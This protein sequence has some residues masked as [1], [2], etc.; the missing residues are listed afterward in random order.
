MKLKCLA[1][2]AASRISRPDP[3]ERQPLHS[4]LTNALG[5]AP[6]TTAAHRVP[7]SSTATR[8][9]SPGSRPGP[10][11]VVRSILDCCL[12][13]ARWVTATV[14]HHARTRVADFC[15]ATRYWSR[16]DEA[17]YGGWPSDTGIKLSDAS[18]WLKRL[19]RAR[20]GPRDSSSIAVVFGRSELNASDH[21]RMSVFVAASEAL[22]ATPP[23]PA[24]N[25]AVPG[26]TAALTA[27]A[28]ADIP[29]TFRG[30]LG[31]RHHLTRQRPQRP[32]APG[33]HRR[34]WCSCQSARSTAS[35][36]G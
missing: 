18:S 3:E 28:M 24:R 12:R 14:A 35:A 26:I 16:A 11:R 29:V 6:S 36:P 33:A 13:S 5:M 30:V 17:T 20:A 19:M 32:G 31:G 1:C 9:R 15:G 25:A 10:S 27:P 23:V 21:P 4:A 8:A 7:P 22:R 2:P 34:R